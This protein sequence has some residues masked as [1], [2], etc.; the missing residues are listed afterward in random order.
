MEKNSFENC[1]KNEESFFLRYGKF[2][3]GEMLQPHKQFKWECRF[4]RRCEMMMR[5]AVEEEMD[6][7]FHQK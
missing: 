3:F 4:F 5:R 7:I 1:E 2:I 6:E